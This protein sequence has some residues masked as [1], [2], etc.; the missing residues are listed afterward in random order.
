MASSL[1]CWEKARVLRSEEVSMG[2]LKWAAI[3]AVLAVIAAVLGFTGL[4]EG[5]ADVAKFLFV[6]FLVGVGI[7]VALGM[8]AYNKAT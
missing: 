1:H 7:L 2:L 3:L 4:A 6:L 8:W 5:L